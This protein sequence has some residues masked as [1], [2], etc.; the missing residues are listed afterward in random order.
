MMPS[1]LFQPATDT[2]SGKIRN[3][4]K[5]WHPEDEPL[6][7][8]APETVFDAGLRNHHIAN[9]AYPIAHKKTIWQY[10]QPADR[11]VDLL[12]NSFDEEICLY[13]HI[14]FCEKRCGFCEYTVLDA[15]S[16]EVEN[17]YHRALLKELDAYAALLP[18]A[19][20]RLLG[21]DIGGGTPSLIDPRKIGEIV[22]RVAGRFGLDPDYGISIETTPKIA[23]T[24]PDRLA[25]YKSF[26]ID[27]ISMGLQMVNPRLLKTYG[28]DLNKTVHNQRAV[29]N[30]RTAGFDRFNIDLMY[31]FARQKLGDF[32]RTLAYT[33]DLAPDYIT[34]YRMRYKGTRIAGEAENMPLFRVTAMYDLARDMLLAAGYAANPGKNV[35]SRI[36]GDPGTS[37]YLTERVVNG[38]PYLGLGLGAQ[39][40]TNNLLAYNLGAASKRME[41]YVSAVDAGAL[42]VQ[43]L[44]LLPPTEGMAKMLSVSFYFGEID[45]RWFRRRFGTTLERRFPDEVAFLIGRRL[46]DYHGEKLRLTPRGAKFINGV[47]P[48]FYSHRVKQ[49]LVELGGD[50]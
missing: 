29:E 16:P 18:S 48:L 25:A 19:N 43:D 49:H 27:R 45:L 41:R 8:L 42:P 4:E 20:R 34:L 36:A 44:Y 17:R 13:V 2:V 6:R 15:H 47:I 50:R 33:I 28:R 1:R 10:R 24:A 38:T 39:T 31:G 22:G 21:L 26:G 32:E 9:T 7:P 23:A 37:R 12:Q 46:M 35:F 40:F 3:H 30:I 14:P 5:P 11:H